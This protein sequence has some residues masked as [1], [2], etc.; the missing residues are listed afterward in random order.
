[1]APAPVTRGCGCGNG[2]LC[3]TAQRLRRRAND[4]AARAIGS[5][6]QTEKGQN[7][8]RQSRRALRDYMRHAGDA[9]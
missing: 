5:D 3:P 2:K 7:A 8:R 9:S 6:E 1:M 4:A